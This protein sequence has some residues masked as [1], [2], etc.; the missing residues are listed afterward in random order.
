MNSVNEVSSRFD[1]KKVILV[2]IKQ[3]KWFIA[4]ILLFLSLAYVLI[5]YA[6]PQYEA[7]ANI[8][9]IS[10]SDKTSPGA[11]FSDIAMF[12]DNEDAKIE[13][14]IVV[15][16]SRGLIKSLTQKL[17]LSLKYFTSG[18]VL[19][20]ELY[21]NNPITVNFIAPDSI[22][23]DI[24]Y[25][26]HI[27][28]ISDSDFNYRIDEDDEPTKAAFG[29]AIPTF[30]G[31]VIVTP[32]TKSVNT[33]AGKS[34]RVELQPLDYVAKVLR[35]RIY[36]FQ[37]AK[38]SKI[39]T[40]G[41]VDPIENRAKDII[42][43]LI[44]EY[45]IY[46]SQVKNKR[47]ENTVNYI[48]ERISLVAS[49]L[50]NVDDSIVN[51]KRGNKVTDVAS[52]AGQFLAS[53]AQNEQEL[54]AINTQK[55][56]LSYMKSSLKKDAT[57]FKMLPSNLGMGDSDLNALSREYNELLNKRKSLLKTAGEKNPLVIELDQ[58]LVS[59]RESLSQS[60]NNSSNSLNIRMSSLQNQSNRIN[61]KILSVPGQ[62]RKLRSIERKQGIK[63]QLY[64]YLL[65]K[66]EESAITLTATAPNL[67]IVDEAF[68]FGI[69]VS[70]NAAGLYV[71]ALFLGLFIP[72]GVIYVK[73]LLDTKIHNKED[74]IY[75]INEIPI[76]GETPRLK[77]SDKNLVEISDRSALSESFRIIR[78]N[79]DYIRKGREVKQYNNV[80]F[81]TS[82]VNG[83]GKSF[84]SMNL[85]LTM[86]RS[87]KKVLIIGA[88]IRNPQVFK[89][90]EKSVDNKVGLTE[91]LV[92]KSISTEDIIKEHTINNIKLDVLLSGKIPPN[93][94]EILMNGR[95]KE[96]FDTVS[97]QYDYVVVDTAPAML[98]T[99]T[100]LISEYAGHTIYVCR[101]GYTD[102]E[103]LRFT[104][105]LHQ[106]KKLNNMMLVVNDV[107][108]SNLGYGGKYGYYVD[109]GKKS[110]FKRGKA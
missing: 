52:E 18:R 46:T 90:L 59:I 34:F 109:T 9:L 11:A 70:P 107:D 19:E 8:M 38:A 84:F 50:V 88:D 68:G 98:V 25:N 64:L 87:K 27:D 97:S 60:I 37:S 105:E 1:L 13:D 22:I 36:V 28:V 69:P 32:K 95:V 76:L 6:T 92:E 75:E 55:R 29:E 21:R 49:D 82:T 79:F 106:D 26:I 5:R 2:Y 71:G 104:K 78:T 51:F 94:A 42:N 100:L 89:G 56:I 41:L 39:I 91:Y 63:E 93:P 72:F 40:I 102:K 17:D 85:A 16:K 96:L 103:L 54:D 110:W 86:A 57:G 12:S 45:D 53:S 73:E 14:E 10:E 43:A 66:R 15:F 67:K 30:F 61:S 23:N 31:E 99:D 83:E 7:I 81:V 20:T 33:L 74:L 80:V 62:E 44:Y 4:S 24:Y 101:G 77:R 108:Q 3:W 48:D 65:Q 35:E 58:N 47:S